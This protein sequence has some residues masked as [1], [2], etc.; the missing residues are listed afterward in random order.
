MKIKGLVPDNYWMFAA[1][2]AVAIVI[3]VG[4]YLMNIK[5][6]GRGSQPMFAIPFALMV[7][8]MYEVCF[9]M[10]EDVKSK[11]AKW[12]ILSL[13]GVFSTSFLV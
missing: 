8:G 4:V 11:K 7:V 9:L 3:F 1:N 13:F 12:F 6:I 5:E 2:V 10:F